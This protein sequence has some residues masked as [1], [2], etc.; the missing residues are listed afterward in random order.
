M[1]NAP[2][3]DC[4]SAE[5]QLLNRVQSIGGLVAIDKRTQLIC[6]CSANI[7]AFTGRRPEELLGRSWNSL[8]RTDQVSS[9]FKPQRAPGLHVAQILESELNGQAMLVANHSLNNTT[10]VEIE[11]ADAESQHYE[12]ADRVVYL[13]ALGGTDTAE[14]AARLRMQKIAGIS[15][16][17]GVMLY[18]FMP[19]WHGEV[20]AESFAP[21]LPPRYGRC[22]RAEF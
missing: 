6:A 3:G 5:L 1:P 2:F 4:K 12:F 19:Y 18:R 9:L 11:P 8:F 13:E 7:H 22:P 20:L 15:H 21:G 17:D 10:L 16:Y 14:D